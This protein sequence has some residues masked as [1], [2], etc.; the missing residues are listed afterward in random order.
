VDLSLAKCYHYCADCLVFCEEGFILKLEIGSDKPENF[1]EYW[2]GQYDTFSY[3]EYATGIPHVLFAVTTLK[4]NGQPN[5]NFHAW[6]CFQ[7]DGGGFFAILAG[8]YQHTHTYANIKRTGEFCINFLSLLYYDKLMDTI[9]NNSDDENEFDA[10]KFTIE[11]AKTVTAPRIM[12]SFLSLE[13]KCQSIS[14]LSDAGISALIIG[15]VMHLSA[16]KD[17]AL[18]LDNKYSKD[19]FMFNIHAPKNLITGEDD[20]SGVATLKVEREY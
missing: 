2:P 11:E 17:F 10:G 16:D 20:V 18:G 13:C 1:I 6:S 19:G 14:D 7:G 12:E 4:E 15:K 8:I 3:L 5:I 9:K